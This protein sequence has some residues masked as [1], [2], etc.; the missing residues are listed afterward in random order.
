MMN[1]QALVVWGAT[2]LVCALLPIHL[3]FRWLP[4]YF[5]A[6]VSYTVWNWLLHKAPEGVSGRAEGG[7]A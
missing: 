4:G 5:V 1:W 2:L 7:A 3:F 6:L